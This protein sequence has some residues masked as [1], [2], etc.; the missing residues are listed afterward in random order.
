MTDN[1]EMTRFELAKNKISTVIDEAGGGSSYTLICANAESG[2]VYER[3]T[4][5]KLAKEL[6][7]SVECSD[8]MIEAGDALA[9]AQKYYDENRSLVT[10]FLTDKD[11]SEH[12]GINLVNLSVADAVNYSV[13]NAEGR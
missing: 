12:N 4:D 3:L 11:Y 1:G 9:A 5:K 7:D 2:A 8:G 6:L 13:S 10:Y